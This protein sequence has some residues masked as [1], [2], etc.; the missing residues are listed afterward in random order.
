MG[1]KAIEYV[2]LATSTNWK[3]QAIVKP[4]FASQANREPVH[5]NEK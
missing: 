4:L 3:A 5:T 2:V 1:V